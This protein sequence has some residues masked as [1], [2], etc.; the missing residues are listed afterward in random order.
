MFDLLHIEGLR[1]GYGEAVVLPK[2]SLGLAESQVLALLGRNGAGKTTLINSIVGH[3]R[4]FGGTGLGL[5][6]CRR[7]AQA[8]G[9]DIG[10]E[11]V[12]GEGSTV[13]VRLPLKRAASPAPDG[14]KDRRSAPRTLQDCRVLVCD[15]NPMTQAVIRASLQPQ[16]RAVEAVSSCEEVREA[17]AGRFDL[18]LADAS[19]LGAERQT[20]LAALRALSDAVKPA[21]VVVMIADIGEDEASRLLGAGA[22]QII[23][24]PIAA[25]RLADELRAGYDVREEAWTARRANPAA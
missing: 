3:T 4:R 16:A 25:S 21:L 10:L 17:G 5:A 8:M 18:V 7:L 22:S 19:A 6:I 23:K 2:L 13:T 12:L 14:W 9:G 15:A 20:R 1:A 11:S 24:K